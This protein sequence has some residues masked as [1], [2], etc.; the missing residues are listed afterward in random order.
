[1]LVD[2]LYIDNKQAVVSAEIGIQWI[3]TLIDTDKKL[4]LPQCINKYT[5]CTASKESS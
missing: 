2:I 3:L 5:S 4:A 1:V